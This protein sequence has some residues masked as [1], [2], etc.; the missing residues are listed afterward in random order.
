MDGGSLALSHSIF[1]IFIVAGFCMPGLFIF[2]DFDDHLQSW[3]HGAFLI[4]C[5]TT[6]AESQAGDDRYT[7]KQ[8]TTLIDT[9]SVSILS[10]NIS[11]YFTTISTSYSIFAVINPDILRDDS[12]P[13][14]R[15][16]NLNSPL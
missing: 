15:I 1:P 14:P 9:V 6:R 8:H 12:V 11:L 7:G 5:S 3:N 4:Q 16:F 2:L 10:N 13:H